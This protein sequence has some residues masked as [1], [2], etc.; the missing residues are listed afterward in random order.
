VSKDYQH[1]ARSLQQRDQKFEKTE[2]VPAIRRERAHL[3][4]NTG[5][6]AEAGVFATC[7]IATMA[8]ENDTFL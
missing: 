2:L 8:E 7:E 1:I 5:A 6:L 3:H 4:F